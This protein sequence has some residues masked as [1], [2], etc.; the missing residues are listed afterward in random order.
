MKSRRRWLLPRLDMPSSFGFPS[1]ECCR[2]L[3]RLFEEKVGR[4][5]ETLDDEFVLGEAA[6]A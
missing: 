2:T 6:E 1:V 3:L 5:R 4:L